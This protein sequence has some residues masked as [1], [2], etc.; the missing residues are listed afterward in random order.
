MLVL[1]TPL[2]VKSYQK[3]YQYQ[4]K[5]EEKRTLYLVVGVKGFASNQSLLHFSADTSVT[6]LK[7]S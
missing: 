7:K 1:C 3:K 6:W 4:L 2:Q 5:L